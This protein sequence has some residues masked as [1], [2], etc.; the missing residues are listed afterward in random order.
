VK[1]VSA[2]IDVAAPL[3]EVWRLVAE[4]E[5]W[6]SWGPTVTGV[7]S[8]ARAVAP[9]ATGRVKTVAGPSLP[10]AIT[11]VEPG[12]SWDWRVAGV[13]ATGHVISDLGDGRTR[14]EFTVPWVLA[15]YVVVL[16]MGLRRLK[17][18]AEA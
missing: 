5:H 4:F 15:P 3:T 8:S 10:F 16:R 14:V 9:G 2:G 11:S 7:T 6:S 13:P 18:L 1:R 12:H 17:T